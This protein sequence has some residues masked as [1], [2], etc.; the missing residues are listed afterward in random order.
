MCGV[1]KVCANVDTARARVP[2][3]APLWRWRSGFHTSTKLCENVHDIADVGVERGVRCRFGF[4]IGD[5]L[6]G[7]GGPPRGEE[8]EDRSEGH[9]GGR[10]WRAREECGRC[11]EDT[12]M[13][14][15]CNILADY[16]DTMFLHTTVLLGLPYPSWTRGERCTLVISCGAECLRCADA[17]RRGCLDALASRHEGDMRAANAAATAST[18]AS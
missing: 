2:P 4:I 9:A 3:N 11:E 16:L 7:S 12:Y 6:C 8:E 13:E 1:I 5:R 15:H 14:Y 17:F 18:L 10:K